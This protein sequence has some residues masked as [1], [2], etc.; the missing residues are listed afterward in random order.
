MEGKTIG[1]LV[2]AVGLVAIVLGTV[3]LH[4]GGP[5]PAPERPRPPPPPEQMMNNV[6]KFSPTI[7]RAMVED[8]SKRFKVPAPAL[9]EW[10]QPFAYFQ[11]LKA[12]R[13]LKVKAPI[14]T[15]HLRVSLEIQRRRASMEGQSFAVDHLILKIE[16]RTQKFL[17]YRVETLV[18]DKNKCTSKGDLPHNALVLE[19]NQAQSRSECL[20]RSD[21]NVDVTG[22]EIIELLPLSAFYVSRLPPNP[23]L[24]DARTAAGHVPMAAPMC[25]QTFSWR[26][27][28][29]GI[30]RKELGWRDVIDF[31]ARHSCDEYTFFRGYRFRT[32]PAA[33]LPARPQ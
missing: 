15:P 6:L 12:R 2:A 23:V 26:E 9:D 18:S 32:N 30:D 8:D 3:A 13:K 33:I 7:Y 14:E 11:E 22:I 25:A 29:E 20:Y 1:L 31:Y 5:P 27:I 28:Q 10:A 16:N 24:Y 17:A 21:E 4:A 19:P